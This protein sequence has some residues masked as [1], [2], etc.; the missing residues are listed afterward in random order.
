[1]IRKIKQRVETGV[2]VL[3]LVVPLTL[4]V[5]AFLGVAGYLAFRETLPPDLAA[6]VTAACGIVLI[7]IVF[8][9][10]RIANSSAGSPNRNSGRENLDLGED[11]EALLREHADPVLTEWVRNNPDRAAVTT[12]A[13]GIAAGY[14]SQ[15]RRILMDF[16]ARYSESERLRRTRRD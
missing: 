3:A 1:M 8:A 14:S 9:V 5:F 2:W 11:F 16:Y 13:L 6:L 10:A 4:C 12:L 7:A 15:F